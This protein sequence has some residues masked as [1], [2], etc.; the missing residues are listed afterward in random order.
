MVGRALR[1]AEVSGHSAA[2][3]PPESSISHAFRPVTSRWAIVHA[4]N[5]RA[6]SFGAGPP[7]AGPSRRA[8][9]AR[10]SQFVRWSG[11]GPARNGSCAAVFAMICTHRN[12]ITF[13]R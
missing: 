10:R 5:F 3:R 12:A 9:G 11:S 8:S 6:D 4:H 1:F 7:G 2:T 13:A